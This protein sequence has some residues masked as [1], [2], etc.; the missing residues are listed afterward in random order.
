MMGKSQER[1]AMFD[2]GVERRRASFKTTAHTP[3]PTHTHMYTQTHT[4]SHLP[5]QYHAQVRTL[6][7]LLVVVSLTRVSTSPLL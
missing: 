1:D 3:T 2:A 5:S 6:P 7:L 4:A